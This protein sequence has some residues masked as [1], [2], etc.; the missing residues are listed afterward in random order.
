MVEAQGE[1]RQSA[2]PGE[3]DARRQAQQLLARLH[4]MPPS[5]SAD[6]AGGLVAHVRISDGV[7]YLGM[8]SASYPYPAAFA[9]LEEVRALFVEELKNAFG[10]GAVD[11]RS[12]IEHITK[13]YYFVHFDRK[14]SRISGNYRDPTFGKALNKVSSDLTQV[15]RIMRGN[16]DEMLTR[17]ESLSG[18]ANKA[19]NLTAAAKDFSGTTRKLSM[20]S[21]FR[22][23]G[24]P[25]LGLA[26]VVLSV[27]LFAADVGGTAA[28]P[29]LAEIG[30]ALKRGAL[31]ATRFALW[32]AG[33]VAALLLVAGGRRCRH[34]KATMLKAAAG[35]GLPWASDFADHML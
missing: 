18:L 11:Y 4:S 20:Q 30:G 29:V 31:C 34:R 26:L 19:A 33:A 15:G 32:G 10:W 6:C 24:A 21:L 9:Y 27:W 12:H 13:P 8:F 25:I 5:F 7:C 2:N 28:G 17:G 16:M 14:I 35:A 23:Y 1:A 22:R 3:Q